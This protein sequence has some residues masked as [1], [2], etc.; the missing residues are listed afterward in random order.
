MTESL[1]LAAL[2]SAFGV[3][4]AMWG[5]KALRSV[6]MIGAIPIRFETSLD[7]TG[8]A[9]AIALGLA[10][11]VVFGAAPALQLSRIDVLR[12]LRSSAA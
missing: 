6:P 5:S 11:G 12:A 7:L 1:L 10:C 4:I 9:F 2:G 8:L 3:V